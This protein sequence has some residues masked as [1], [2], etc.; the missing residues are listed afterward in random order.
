MA[1][2][3]EKN[4]QIALERIA[5][6]V[7]TETAK[8]I[9]DDGTKLH[10]AMRYAALGGG[11]KLRPFLV[12]ESAA[13]FGIPAGNTIRIGTALECLHTYSLVHDDL[14]AMDD[15][16]LRRGLATVHRIFD[17]AT[18]ILAGDALLTLAFEILSAPA[19]HT[20][21]SIR[22]QLVLQLAKAAGS[23]G[24]VGGQMLDIEAETKSYSSLAAISEMQAMKTS[25]L[26]RFA[27]E[28]GPTLAQQDPTK[29]RQYAEYLGLAFQIADDIL[30]VE[31]NA[32]ALGKATQKDKAK[33]KAT[34]VDFL[35]LDGA[36][37]EAIRLSAAAIDSLTE[38]GNRADML[39]AA[40]RFVVN[41]RK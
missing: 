37:R 19:T 29:L 1:A 24:M 41:R 7:E 22:A 31:S 21:P 25:A 23:K 30:D 34:F 33:G 36:K 12:T 11:K 4:F 6:L 10:A 5:N 16:D 15:D 14:P 32:G 28:S 38:Y 40:A 39:C 26:F 20:D 35:G 9:P 18:A 3:D 27:C 2:P 8:L 13:V 17:D